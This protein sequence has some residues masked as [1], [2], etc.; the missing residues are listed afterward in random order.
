[1][2]FIP[3]SYPIGLVPKQ[4]IFDS[5]TGVTNKL[6]KVETGAGKGEQERDCGGAKLEKKCKIVLHNMRHLKICI[7][8]IHGFYL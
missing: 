3:N 2:I 7:D 1:M 8:S 6:V 5:N 4:S